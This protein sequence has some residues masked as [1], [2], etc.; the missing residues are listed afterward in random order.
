[1][2][3]VG[4]A[5]STDAWSVFKGSSHSQRHTCFG[6]RLRSVTFVWGLCVQAANLLHSHTTMFRRHIDEVLTAAGQIVSLLE[7]L[8][9]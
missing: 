9:V 4:H 3:E 2:L 8:W 7:E 6:L 1:V 5:R